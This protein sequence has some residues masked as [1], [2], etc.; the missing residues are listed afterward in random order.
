VRLLGR[1]EERLLKELRHCTIRQGLPELLDCPGFVQR[2]DLPEQLS[3]AHVY[4]GPSFSEGGPG[5]SYL[6]AMA[7]GLP[8]VA[9]EGTGAAEVIV[10]GKTGLLAR[11]GDAESV[12]SSLRQLLSDHSLRQAMGSRG[13]DFVC[14]EADS[15]LCL[16]RLEAFYESVVSPSR[17]CR[18]AAGAVP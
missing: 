14:D 6:E 15:Q 16:K 12:A 4:A 17:V 1:G 10:A 9:S 18:A 7:C 2:R 5:L 8:V 13:R 3:R 11:P